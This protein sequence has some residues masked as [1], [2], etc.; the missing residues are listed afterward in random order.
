[1]TIYCYHNVFIVIIKYRYWEI[2]FFFMCHMW[3]TNI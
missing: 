1:M 3:R 2:F